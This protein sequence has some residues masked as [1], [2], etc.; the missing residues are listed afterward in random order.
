MVADNGN[1]D[2]AGFEGKASDAAYDLHAAVTKTG[3][4]LI[5]V[6]FTEEVSDLAGT[7]RTVQEAMRRAIGEQQGSA[8]L[9][10]GGFGRGALLARFAL[11]MMERQMMDHQT[12]AYFSYNSTRPANQDETDALESVGTMPQRPRALKLTVGVADV[13][14]LSEKDDQFRSDFSDTFYSNETATTS[15]MTAPAG[16]WLLGN[17][18]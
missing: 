13:E 3:R 11:A 15:L 12:E 9:T 7:A 5:L 1:S 16:Q 17:L 8:P 2:M 10:V 6:G 4:D 18:S 14:G